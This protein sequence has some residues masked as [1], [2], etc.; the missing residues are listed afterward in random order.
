MAGTLICLDTNYLILGLTEGAQEAARLIAWARAQEPLVTP[1]VAW[2]EF[3]CG[4]VTP[5]QVATM[6]AF[7]T[8]V[9][10]LGEPQAFEAARLFNAVGRRRS[11]RV[12]A[13]IAGCA[14]VAGARLATNNRD[15]FAA[16]VPFGLNLM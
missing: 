5:I 12:D 11:L 15:H 14:V 3:L 13:M 2:F 6:R 7:L 9:I 8:E 4:P 16:F 1:A 10:V